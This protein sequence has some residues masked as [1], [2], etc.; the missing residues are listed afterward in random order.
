MKFTIENFLRP[1]LS[2]MDA[3]QVLKYL[4]DNNMINYTAVRNVAIREHYHSMKCADRK[5]ARLE[6]ADTFCLSP[7]YVDVILYSNSTGRKNYNTE[8]AEK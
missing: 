5:Q 6:I 8:F 7:D 4:I 2:K 1:V 3:E